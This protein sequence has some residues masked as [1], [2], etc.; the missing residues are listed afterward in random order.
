MAPNTTSALD[1]TVAALMAD[2]KQLAELLEG[3]V[4]TAAY[5]ASK[6]EWSMEDNFATT[7]ALASNLGARLLDEDLIAIATEGGYE[8]HPDDLEERLLPFLPRDEDQDE[9]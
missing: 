6:A 2:P 7:E 5:L 3:F 4:A 8:L 1:R 9:A